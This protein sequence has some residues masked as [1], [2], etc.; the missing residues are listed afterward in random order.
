MEEGKNLL[1]EG[2]VV[3]Q[4]EVVVVVLEVGTGDMQLL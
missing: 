2:E 1:V 4:V 3:F